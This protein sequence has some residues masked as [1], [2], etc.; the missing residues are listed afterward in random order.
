MMLQILHYFYQ[1]Q[2]PTFD[3]PKI[4]TPS[5]VY[6]FEFF[7]Y[8]A[9][10]TIWLSNQILTSCAFD[11][12]LVWE[13]SSSLLESSNLNSSIFLVSCR[14]YWT[15]YSAVS[16]KPWNKLCKVLI[17]SDGWSAF[18]ANFWAKY[19]SISLAVDWRELE[20]SSK[21]TSSRSLLA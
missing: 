4:N 17:Y 15:A 7:S 8:G 10:P 3:F 16:F 21:S 9:L 6:L 12:S 20:T 5:I 1:K 18:S 2:H 13:S 11:F 14:P 19:Y